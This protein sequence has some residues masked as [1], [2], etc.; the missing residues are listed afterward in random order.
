M[1]DQKLLI[2]TGVVLEI[3]QMHRHTHTHT[4]WETKQF[5]RS[6]FSY[7]KYAERDIFSNV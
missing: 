7:A 3:L 6:H 1:A 5:N 4:K 2:S